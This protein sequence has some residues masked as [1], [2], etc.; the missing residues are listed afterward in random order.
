MIEAAS[1]QFR[2]TVQAAMATRAWSAT[3]TA[4]E[5]GI[6]QGTMTRVMQAHHVQQAT[7]SKLRLALAITPAALPPPVEN[8]ADLTA[9]LAQILAETVETNRLLRSMAVRSG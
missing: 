7:I 5:A 8:T 1:S 4:R 6:A 2:D 3:R 9:M